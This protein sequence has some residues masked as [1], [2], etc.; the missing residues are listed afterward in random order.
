MDAGHETLRVLRLAYRTLP[1]PFRRLDDG[2]DAAAGEFATQIGRDAQPL[3]AAHACD[4]YAIAATLNSAAMSD[5]DHGREA[6][7]A[8][9]AAAAGRE[10]DYLVNVYECVSWA[11]ALRYAACKARATGRARTL[12]LQVVDADLHGLQAAWRTRTYGFARFGI[13]SLLL[14]VEPDGVQVTTGIAP[15]DR[16]MM[17]F[18]TALRATLR[19]EPA[20]VLAVPF[21]PEPTRSAFRKTIPGLRA[22]E[23]LHDR[24]GHCFGSDPWIAL[25]RHLDRGEASRSFLLGSLALSGYIGLARVGVDPDAACAVEE[26]A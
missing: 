24:Y 22:T 17:K 19:D 16:S 25:G 13:T 4:D 21:F 11:L 9:V 5:P 2:L 1:T 12:L 20:R 14:R 6:F 3:L 18:G 26:V 10:P 15:V 8:R 7:V 23:D